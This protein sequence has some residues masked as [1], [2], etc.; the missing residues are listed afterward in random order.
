MAGKNENDVFAAI[1]K[2]CQ[3][4]AAK[5]ITN[6]AKKAQEDIIKEADKYL[7]NYY[8]WKPKRYK[9]T[10]QLQK[11]IKPIFKNNGIEN[12]GSI[13]IGVEYDASALIGAYK[14]NSWYHQTGTFWI[15]KSNGLFDYDSQNNGIPSPSWILDNY[16]SGI[17]K[18]GD[19]RN[20]QH[21][22]AEST[23]KL[24]QRFFNTQLRDHINQYIGKEL[25]NVITSKL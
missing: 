19:G 13:E 25:F 18:W 14:S 24:M 2:D 4:I 15:S 12:G 1:L 7:Q 11:A 6:A 5:A 23:D 10:Y 21:Q 8:R 20:E 9:R 17:H 16:M 22:D 3:A